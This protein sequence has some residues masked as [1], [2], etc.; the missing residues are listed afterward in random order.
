MKKLWHFEIVKIGQNLHLN[1][2]GFRRAGHIYMRYTFYRAEEIAIIILC[3]C[4]AGPI[5]NYSSTVASMLI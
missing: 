2:E 1:M 4:I 5:K 3:K